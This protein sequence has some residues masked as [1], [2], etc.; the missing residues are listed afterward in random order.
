MAH[1]ETT[2]DFGALL[3]MNPTQRILAAQVLWDSVVQSDNVP[4]TSPAQR[5]EIERRIALAD[6]GQM[7]SFTWE[8]V[9]AS[10]PRH[11]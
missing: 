11:Q 10:L 1:T 9:K 4:A 3:R 6:A 7:R 8:D 2:I 5:A